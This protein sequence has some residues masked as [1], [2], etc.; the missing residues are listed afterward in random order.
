MMNL[1][2]IILSL[3]IVLPTLSV[4]GQ[5]SNIQGLDNVVIR[6]RKYE[7][8]RGSAY[9]YPEWTS[10][11]LTDKAGKHY[12]NLQ[13]KYDAYL[14]RV[15]LNQDGQVLEINASAY[16]KFTLNF[17]E[18]GTNKIIKHTF[19][20]GYE[21][22]GFS[23][24]SYFDLIRDGKITLLKKYKTSFVDENLSGYGTSDQKKSFQTKIL[25]FVLLE[26]GSAKEIKLNK[27]SI[28]ETFPEQSSNIEG[29]IKE[30]KIKVKTEQDLI[31]IIEFLEAN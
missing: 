13:L 5:I 15:E 24:T 20:T 22:K 18:P 27:K 6:T 8:V 29:F 16:P 23:K 17:V 31:D 1:N 2:L 7:D 25:Y 10:G 26:D 28:L 4:K 9:L 11:T 19:S 30:R 14:D 3:L 21:I 12:P